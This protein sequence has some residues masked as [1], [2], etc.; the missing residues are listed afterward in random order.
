VGVNWKIASASGVLEDRLTD[1][2]GVVEMHLKSGEAAVEL[3]I[4]VR[5]ED[6]EATRQFVIQPALA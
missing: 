3:G 1:K 5:L 6:R 4:K 2:A